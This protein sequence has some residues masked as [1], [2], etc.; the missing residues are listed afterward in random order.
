MWIEREVEVALDCIRTLSWEWENIAYY[1]PSS[2]ITIHR[3]TYPTMAGRRFK[4]TMVNEDTEEKV[5]MAVRGG[6]TSWDEGGYWRTLSSGY[7]DYYSW[8]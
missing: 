1:Q 7:Y 3:D 2:I 4:M 5:H 6:G 8:M